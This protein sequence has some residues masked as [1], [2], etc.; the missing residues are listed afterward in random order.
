LGQLDYENV[1]V[2]L[3]EGLRNLELESFVF[4]GVVVGCGVLRSATA[5]AF[6]VLKIESEEKS[7]K[8]RRGD[9]LS[10]AEVGEGLNP[11]NKLIL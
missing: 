5:G 7:L 9:N 4:Q 3:E 11:L 6:I 10:L 2:L 1:G 8:D